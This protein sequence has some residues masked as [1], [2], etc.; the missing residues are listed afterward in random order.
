MKN[1]HHRLNCREK[2]RIYATMLRA[3]DEKQRA[4]YSAVLDQK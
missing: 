1:N 4:R 3:M 2:S